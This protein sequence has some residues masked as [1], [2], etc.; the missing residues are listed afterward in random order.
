M[1][2]DGK[3]YCVIISLYLYKCIIHL[4]VFDYDISI[5]FVIQTENKNLLIIIEAQKLKV[6]L[7]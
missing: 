1:K 2:I 6:V 3:L 4:L 7:N 5:L